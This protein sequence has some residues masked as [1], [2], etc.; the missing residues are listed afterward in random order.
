[1]QTTGALQT[2]R[3]PTKWSGQVNGIGSAPWVTPE[4][5]CMRL[6]HEMVATGSHDV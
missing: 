3:L 6:D 4:R 5:D 1:V 2:D